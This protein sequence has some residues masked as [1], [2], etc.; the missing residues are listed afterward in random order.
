[1]DQQSLED[2]LAFIELRNVTLAANRRH[3]SQPAYSRRLKNLEAN[4]DIDLVDRSG[5]PAVPTKA[6]IGMK[7]EIELALVSLKRVNKIFKGT[8]KYNQTIHIAAVH[9]LSAGPLPYVINKIGEKIDDLG[10]RL[11]SANQDV[12]F[13]LLMTEEVSVMLAYETVN[14]PLLVPL[15]LFKKTDVTND[16][17]VPVCSVGFRKKLDK[18]LSNNEAIPLIN[19]PEDIF[20]G[21]VMHNDVLSQSPHNFSEKLVAGMS[22]VVLSAVLAGGGVAWLPKSVIKDELKKNELQIIEQPGFLKI[23]LTIVILRLR[24]EDTEG[25]NEMWKAFVIALAETVNA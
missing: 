15:D 11:H 3:I 4:H 1:M 16:Q 12:C 22:G 14:Q 8:T 5:R 23:D 13:Q 9:S 10:V 20:L 6:L 21:R 25:L 17:L 2:L 24:K 7:R 18:Y 19:Y